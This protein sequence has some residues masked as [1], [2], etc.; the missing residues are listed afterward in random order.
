MV[1]NS[2]F[3]KKLGVKYPIIL[4]P[5]GGGPGTPEL[6]ATVSN[7]GGLGSLAAAYLKPDQISKDIQRIR[8]LTDRPFAVNLFAGGYDTSYRGDGRPMLEVLAEIHQAL[9]LPAPS[10]PDV[11]PDPFNDQFEVILDARPS[12]FSFTF[13]IPASD[14]MARL[15]A[16]G[17][18]AIG[19]A[20]TVDE[21]VLLEQSGV[22]AI[23]A[24]GAEAGAHRGTFLNSFGASMVPTLELVRTIHD[25]VSVP[26]IASGGL[27]DGRDIAESFSCGA[28]AAQLGTAFLTCPESGTSQSYRNAIVNARV[29]TTVV[30]RAF[31]GRPARGLSNTFITR[32]EGKEN[33]ILPYPIQNI[34]TRPMR[35]AAAKK[36]ESGFQSLWAGRGVTRS[37]SMPAGELVQKLVEEMK[38]AG[39]AFA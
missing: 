16:N 10:L 13:G 35:N 21:A 17:V 4:A 24:Q 18:L 22:A 34:L 6:V 30:T 28:S 27:M 5:M 20:T 11:P 31:S 29:D 1:T 36:G 15:K 9:D 23:V 26:V 39:V 19:T 2:D 12:V 3:A 38:E 37:R 8:K 33:V 7:S 25:R 14:A 32:L